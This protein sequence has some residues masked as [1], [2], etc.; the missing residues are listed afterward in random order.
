MEVHGEGYCCVVYTGY[1][2]EDVIMEKKR[3]KLRGVFILY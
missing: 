3:R 1:V 2:R